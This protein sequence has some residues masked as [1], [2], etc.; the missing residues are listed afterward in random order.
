MQPT[1]IVLLVIAA[2]AHASWNFLGKSRS[3]GIAFFL[4]ATAA[5]TCFL[6]PAV[7]YR[8][9][10]TASFTAEVWLLLLGTGFCQ[11]IYF[12]GL[13]GAYRSGHMS[14][15]YPL[16]RSSPAIVLLIVAFMLGRRH[17]VSW[18][19]AAG[20]V[21]V[22]GGC[23]FLPM[24]FFSDFRVKNY[25]NATCLFALMAALGTAGYSLIDDHA[26]RI[27]RSFP[28]NEGAHTHTTL[29]YTFWEGVF[30][31]GWLGIFNLA[32]GEWRAIKGVVKGHT[33]YVVVAGI[34][35]YITYALVLI[36]MKYADNVSYVVGFRQLSIPL[37]A[38]M[39]I[40]FL[41]EPRPLPKL[42]GVA[43]IFAGVVM[44]A[45]GRN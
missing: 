29:V 36:S 6:F 5:G 44:V 12:S 45:A 28:I 7:L 13:A 37:G 20:I 10:A 34:A 33:G 24:K 30:V 14:I 39:G 42:L 32:S 38:L 16:A 35:I 31:V 23:F 26:L 27:L 41:R 3:P 22:V 4:V 11:A 15:A 40:T 8:T 2:F 19:C 17:E 21:C 18:V 43:I 9:A 1:A 25:L